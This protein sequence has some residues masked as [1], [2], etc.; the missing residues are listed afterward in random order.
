MAAYR[1]DHQ[2]AD[3]A[4]AFI[5]SLKHSTGKHSGE[6]FV[7]LPFQREIVRDIFGKVRKDG[8]RQI[9]KSYISI[10][11][12]N[13]KTALIAA[14]VLYLLFCDGEPDALIVSASSTRDQA[15]LVY[16]A[17]KD[18]ITQDAYL[19]SICAV[20]DS[21][22]EIVNLLTGSSYRALSSDGSGA[23]GL[24][25]S[26]VIFDE[27]HAWLKP[28]AQ[29]LYDALTS[30]SGMRQQPLHISIT[31]AGH[32]QSSLCFREYEYA[33]SVIAATIIDPSYAA[34]IF[35]VPQDADWRDRSLWK[36]ANPALGQTV[37]LD[38]LEQ[39]FAKAETSA[40]EEAKFR[41]LYLNQWV[42]SDV[43]FIRLEDWDANVFS[44]DRD[45]LK[46]EKCFIGLDLSS[47]IDITAAVAVFPREDGIFKVIPQFFIPAENL[48]KRALKDKVPYPDWVA[49][50]HIITTPG[51]V[52]DFAFV[53]K[54][55]N[56]MA[57]QYD[58]KEVV[59]DRWGAQLLS[60]QLQ[61]DG[62][63]V[64]GF[65]Q[66][67]ASMSEPTKELLAQTLQRNIHHGGNPVL[68]WMVSSLSV[69]S[70]PACNI[71]PI[72]PDT[73]KSSKRID[74]CVALVMALGRAI[75]HRNVE[76]PVSVYEERGVLVF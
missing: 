42:G 19:R 1:F 60:Q 12:K 11:R 13:G 22:K 75:V 63:T 35:E 9:R 6:P 2:A 27:L 59:I 70:D 16:K 43:P 44:V 17:C 49:A 69:A 39:E 67:F 14:I 66:G 45:S 53:R 54:Y 68:R 61:D 34:W 50:G 31:T 25:P 10:A 24:N 46:G 18:Y 41:R 29:E 73:R 28:S 62:L 48:H 74:G 33:K 37:T 55:L 20:K 3:L 76:T 4:C 57:K 58:V 72:K 5:E 32:E 71:K 52:V 36:L 40:F 15:A 21:R 23:H 8:T 7:L 30:G 56:D 26:C 65:G 51:N 64:V 47:K 38:F